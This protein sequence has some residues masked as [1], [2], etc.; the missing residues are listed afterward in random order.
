MLTD[1]DLSRFQE[2][3]AVAQGGDAPQAHDLLQEL[4]RT[5][6]AESSVWL[7]HAFTAPTLTQSARSIE[8]AARLNPGDPNLGPARQWLAERRQAAPPPVPPVP[9]PGQAGAVR[10]VKKA[11]R[12]LVVALVVVLGL[13]LVAGLAG[14]LSEATASYISY[15]STEDIVRSGQVGDRVSIR[16]SAEF[17]HTELQYEYGN[18]G[19]LIR[20]PGSGFKAGPHT[21]YLQ[22]VGRETKAGFRFHPSDPVVMINFLVAEVKRIE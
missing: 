19:L 11:G 20:P 22:I 9:P 2:A 15:T 6:S 13:G 17:I 7:W 5:N 10:S 8:E 3:V 12:V 21:Y 4:L 18:R 16:L 14:W 1:T